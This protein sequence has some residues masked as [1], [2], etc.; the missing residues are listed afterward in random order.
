MDC[1]EI[2]SGEPFSIEESDGTEDVFPPWPNDW[3]VSSSNVNVVKDAVEKIKSSGAHYFYKGNYLDAERKYKKA[4]RYIDW[5][6][7]ENAADAGNEEINKMRLTIILNLATT[8]HKLDKHKEV[9]H[10]CT[11]VGLFN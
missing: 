2:K 5:Y 3:E 7:H 11:Q 1:G 9:V 10:L 6:L 4:L 8:K